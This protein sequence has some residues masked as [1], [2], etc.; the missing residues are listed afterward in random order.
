MDR[1]IWIDHVR[2]GFRSRVLRFSGS[3]PQPD[4]IKF[5]SEE[6]FWSTETVVQYS[7][8]DWLQNIHV[9]H[10]KSNGCTSRKETYSDRSWTIFLWRIQT[11]AGPQRSQWRRYSF[12]QSKRLFYIQEREIWRFNWR[13][14]HHHTTHGY[15]GDGARC[16]ARKAS[17]PE[18]NQQGNTSHL[19]ASDLCLLNGAR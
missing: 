15:T 19:R 5:S 4:S 1:Y 3:D 14:N 7:W 8:W 16:G 12:I 11:E 17:S 18:A 13:W 2:L 6:R 9:Q 10:N